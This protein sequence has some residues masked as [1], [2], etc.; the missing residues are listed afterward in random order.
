[1]ESEHKQ[2]KKDDVLLL[3]PFIFLSASCVNV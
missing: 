1:M 2:S 3:L